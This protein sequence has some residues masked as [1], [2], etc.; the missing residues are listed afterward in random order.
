MGVD[1]QGPD[2]RARA[3]TSVVSGRLLEELDYHLEGV[4]SPTSA[5][6]TSC[7]IALAKM[8]VAPAVRH[9][10]RAHGLCQRLCSAGEA[11]LV[12]PLPPVHRT[13]PTA[14]YGVHSLHGDAAFGL[15]SLALLCFEDGTRANLDFISSPTLI[16]LAMR[17]LLEGLPGVAA[18]DAALS[19]AL[20]TSAHGA[21]ATSAQASAS[22]TSSHCQ[23]QRSS[24]SSRAR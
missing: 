8:L 6:R 4:T 21:A 17:L 19:A 14:Q 23:W 20:A 15:L 1:G 16:T 22:S 11:C 2:K 9:S 24:S 5:V 12:A 7:I 13:H 10:F 18:S 3:S